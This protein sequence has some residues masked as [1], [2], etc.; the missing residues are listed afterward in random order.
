MRLTVED[1]GH[2]V[3]PLYRRVGGGFTRNKIAA[4]GKE[5]V[6]PDRYNEARKWAKER[7]LSIRKTESKYPFIIVDDDTQMVRADLAKKINKLGR[8]MKRYVWMGE[9]WRTR[10]RQQQLWNEYVNRNYAPPTVAR[11][12]T[13]NHESGNA[14]DISLFMNGLNSSY[15]NV[16]H[17][18][19][20]RSL[21]RKMGLGLPVPQEYWHVEITPFWRA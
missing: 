4:L 13:S 18:T 16:G 12:G 14:A 19:K 1:I 8:K 10:A 2:N 6:N 21:M 17:V 7:N 15:T 11:P 3:R 5:T 20:A 9:G